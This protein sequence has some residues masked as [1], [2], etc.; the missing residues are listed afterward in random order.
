[1]VQSRL[2]QAIEG[3][4]LPAWPPAALAASARAEAML[5]HRFGRALRLL[6]SVCGFEGALARGVLQ[7]RW[8]RRGVAGQGRSY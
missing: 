7:V 6:Q 5:A 1:M 4:A 2:E 8:R 3:I